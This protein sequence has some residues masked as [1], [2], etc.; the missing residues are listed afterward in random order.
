MTAADHSLNPLIGGRNKY[1]H[2]GSLNHCYK[3]QAVFTFSLGGEGIAQEV[4]H[5]LW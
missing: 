3:V 2:L 4:N 1:T 5:G